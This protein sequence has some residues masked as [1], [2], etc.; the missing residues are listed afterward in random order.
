LAA[1][2]AV[3]IIMVLNPFLTLG[4]GGG[5]IAGF[6][7]ESEHEYRAIAINNIGS[8]RFIYILF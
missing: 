1:K 2:A 8:R 7:A 4:V 5:S 3:S 6:D